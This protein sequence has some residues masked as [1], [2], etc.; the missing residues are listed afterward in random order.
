MIKEVKKIYSI[1]LVKY[2]GANVFELLEFSGASGFYYSGN[3]LVLKNIRI[4][5]FGITKDIKISKGSY[6]VKDEEDSSIFVVDN[7]K[8]L[9]D[10]EFKGDISIEDEDLIKELFDS[11]AQE[12]DDKNEICG[13]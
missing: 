7:I 8:S 4:N 2:E 13:E 12:A 10:I 11:Y 3:N 9:I 5:L 1:K 6:L